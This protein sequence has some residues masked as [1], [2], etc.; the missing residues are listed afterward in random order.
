LE[1]WKLEPR[2][3]DPAWSELANPE[4]IVLKTEGSRIYVV[5][6][7]NTTTKTGLLKN[8]QPGA[9]Y[10][11]QWYDPRTGKYRDVPGPV[12][13]SSSGEWDMPPKPDDQDWLLVVQLE[14]QDEQS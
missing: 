12:Q 5:Y 3:N 7:A 4:R 13:P 6:F 10:T 8:M 9:S 1:W 11:A 2:Y 14:K